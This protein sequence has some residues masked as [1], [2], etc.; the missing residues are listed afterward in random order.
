MSGREKFFTHLI[1]RAEEIFL[2]KNITELKVPC[3]DRRF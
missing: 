1:I 3:G 2:S